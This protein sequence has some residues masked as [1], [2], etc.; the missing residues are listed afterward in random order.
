MEKMDLYSWS[1]S[2]HNSNLAL[3]DH[4]YARKEEKYGH[5][6]KTSRWPDFSGEVQ[7]FLFFKNYVSRIQWTKQE[8]VICRLGSYTESTI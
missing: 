4:V 5:I 6:M 1:R 2:D 3:S 8:E 7:Y